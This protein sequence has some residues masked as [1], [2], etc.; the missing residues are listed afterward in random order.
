MASCYGPFNLRIGGAR[1]LFALP[2]LSQTSLQ[3]DLDCVMAAPV[4][5]IIYMDNHTDR[6]SR[7]SQVAEGVRFSGLKSPSMLFA[8]AWSCWLCRTVSSCLHRNGWQLSVKRWRSV[9]APQNLRPRV[10]A[11]KRW[12]AHSGSVKSCFPKWRSISSISRSCS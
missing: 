3:L 1:A 8:D 5:F 4:L 7:Y 9:S 11:K 2:P 6:I 10:P 12:I